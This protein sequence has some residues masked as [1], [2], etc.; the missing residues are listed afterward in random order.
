MSL[1][2]LGLKRRRWRCGQPGIQYRQIQ[3][4]K[5]YLPPGY[6]GQR[7]AKTLEQGQHGP[8][9]GQHFRRPLPDPVRPGQQCQRQQNAPP[10][11]LVLKVVRYDAGELRPIGMK[12]ATACCSP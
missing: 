7:Q 5:D 3:P 12:A 8:V 11:P 10:R 9:L 6:Q 4:D 1:F 2:A